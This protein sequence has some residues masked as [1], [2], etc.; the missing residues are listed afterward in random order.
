[1]RIFWCY[2]RYFGIYLFV[3][4]TVAGSYTTLFGATIVATVQ[5]ALVFPQTVAVFPQTAF[6][7]FQTAFVFFQTAFV[8]FQTAAVFFQAA[9]AF[10]A[11]H[12]SWPV[13]TK[14]AP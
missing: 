14:V 5:V 6:V 4:Q 13:A 9:F 7:F 10:S 2:K 1:V 8:F 12:F 3:L 11:H